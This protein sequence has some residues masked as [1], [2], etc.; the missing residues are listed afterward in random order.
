MVKYQNIESDS[1]FLE[2]YNMLYQDTSNIYDRKWNPIFAWHVMTALFFIA[3][4]II[5]EHNTSLRNLRT[6]IYT[7]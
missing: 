7:G 1:C 3:Y 6:I 4:I 5:S 2:L